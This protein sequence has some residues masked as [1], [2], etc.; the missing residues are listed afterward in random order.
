VYKL[1]CEEERLGLARGIWG[2]SGF[3]QFEKAFRRG[4]LKKSWGGGGQ[5]VYVAGGGDRGWRS[6]GW[7]AGGNIR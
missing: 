1:A 4:M 5:R 3:D 2:V 6:E 7:I